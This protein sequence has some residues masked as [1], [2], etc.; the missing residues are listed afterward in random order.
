[1]PVCYKRS[2][3]VFVLFA[4]LGLVD[5]DTFFKGKIDVKHEPRVVGISLLTGKT[6]N[7]DNAQ[8]TLLSTL[9]AKNWIPQS[10]ILK[11]FDVDQHDLKKLADEGFL[12]SDE[13]YPVAAE[14]RLRDNRIDTVHWNPYQ[15]FAYMRTRW[16][17]TGS[18]IEAPSDLMGSLNDYGQL[19]NVYGKPAPHFHQVNSKGRIKLPRIEQKEGIFKTLLSRQTT[20]HFRLDKSLPSDD[21]STLLLYTFGYHGTHTLADGYTVL[22]KTS[23]SG[24]SLH[25]VE[26]YPLIL[27]VEGISPGLYHYNVR[28]HC[29]DLIEEIPVGEGRKLAKQITTG[30]DYFHSA[31]IMVILTGRFNRNFWKYRNHQK[32]L[33]V[34]EM[35]AA[36][37][38]QTFYL[39]GTELGL[40]TF[41][42]AAIVDE[43]IEKVLDL[44]VLEEGAMMVV[45]CG[46]PLNEEIPGG[47]RFEPR[48]D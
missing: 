20:R 21:L 24:G 2:S 44:P 12:L 6:E 4:D 5:L 23:P 22:R 35:D 18:E 41:V 3:Y 29:L 11:N 39:I 16:L 14:M 28:D 42:T 10:D 1:M 19:V 15:A 25:P 37:L 33:K 34:V 8:V 9:D 17:D 26:A 48:I 38:S 43:L 7:L 13:D 46:Y 30:Q 31:N 47:F 40:G 45:G 32:A 36:H 27:N